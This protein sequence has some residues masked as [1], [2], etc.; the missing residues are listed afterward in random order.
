MEAEPA[1]SGPPSTEATDALASTEA[2]ALSLGNPLIAEEKM[3]KESECLVD[4]TENVI[5]LR[6]DTSIDVPTQD[7]EPADAASK[8]T[9]EDALSLGNPLI[10][11]EKMA[12]ESECLVDPTENVVALR[13]D[14]SIDVPTQDK[15]PAD[16]AS[17]PGK[18]KSHV[19]E[20]ENKEPSGI[21]K[22][23]FEDRKKGEESKKVTFKTGENNDIV[24]TQSN[25]SI[26]IPTQPM[27]IVRKSNLGKRKIEPEDEEK[28]KNAQIRKDKSDEQRKKS[29]RKTKGDH[30]F[31]S[32]DK[33]SYHTWG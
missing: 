7:K 13:S 22:E 30:Q 3:A 5:A 18:E 33:S 8:P 10:A 17:K 29:T 1:V 32:L 20:G 16:A 15:E 24:A 25:T 31:F 26:D 4:S 27:E 21:R 9:D 19:E 23:A 12:K 6:S 2:D 11:E 14:T 28:K